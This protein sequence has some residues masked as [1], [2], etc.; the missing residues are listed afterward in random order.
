MTAPNY[1]ETTVSGTR[2]RRSQAVSVTNPYN[3]PDNMRVIF[4]EEDV[5]SLPDST[6]V[7]FPIGTVE[8][9]FS[10]NES[11]PLLDLQTNQVIGSMT[12]LEF[13]AILYSLYMKIAKDRD[14]AQ[15]LQVN[16]Q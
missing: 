1:K 13:Y 12:H 15:A 7:K 11:F 3:D 9:T 2:W 4:M 5:L 10:P 14:D 16:Q 6:I 8:K